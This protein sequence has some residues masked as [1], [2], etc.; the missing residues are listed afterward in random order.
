MLM[1]RRVFVLIVSMTMLG[2]KAGLA[3]DLELQRLRYLRR[4]RAG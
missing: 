4:K 1:R 3:L 2:M